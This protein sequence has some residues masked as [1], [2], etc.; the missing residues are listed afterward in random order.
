MIV[1]GQA[2]RE[3]FNDKSVVSGEND[4]GERLDLTLASLL[5]NGV[6]DMIGVCLY[7]SECQ[8]SSHKIISHLDTLNINFLLQPRF[9]SALTN[10]QY[11]FR[12][13][14]LIRN[15]VPQNALQAVDQP[16]VPAETLWQ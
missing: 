1:G 4:A 11:Y 2:V 6:A 15:S 5:I 10:C 9:V 7:M 12:L 3:D 16:S 8:M 14:F 13:H